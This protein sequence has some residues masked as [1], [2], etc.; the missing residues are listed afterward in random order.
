MENEG[1]IWTLMKMGDEAAFETLFHHHYPLLFN[2]ARRFNVDAHLIEESVQ[3]LFIKIW[4]NKA[5]LGQ[6][7][8]IKHYL[9]KSLRNTIH[10]KLSARRRELY[11]DSWDHLL[12]FHLSYTPEDNTYPFTGLSDEI[13]HSLNQLTAR[14]REAI[15]LFYFEDLDYQEIADLLEINIGGA[16]KLIYRALDSLKANY[17]RSGSV[18]PPVQ[19]RKMKR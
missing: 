2:Y 18:L 10:N 15:Y 11:V 19:L 1:K 14:Q 3:E 5:N 9:F 8:S 16:Y 13:Q 12:E 4:Q 7:A 6:P 17:T